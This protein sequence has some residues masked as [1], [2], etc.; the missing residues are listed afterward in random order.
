M[1][2]G[3]VINTITKSLKKEGYDAQVILS[4]QLHTDEIQVR[5]RIKDSEGT[6]MDFLSKE[7]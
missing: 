3:H 6:T 1:E 2:T 5:L 4:E 7:K